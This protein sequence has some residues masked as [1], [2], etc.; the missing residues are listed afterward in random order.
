MMDIHFLE[1][2]IHSYYLCSSIHSLKYMNLC[3]RFKQADT[4]KTNKNLGGIGTSLSLLGLIF[5]VDCTTKT[6]ALILVVIYGVS[7][8]A[9]IT[10]AFTAAFTIAP[11]FT[12]I[13]HS[14][15]GFAGGIAFLL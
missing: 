9:N 12:G 8:S 14:L 5:L 4:H 3:V 7:F 15:A 10:G 6:L 1:R 13:I 11:P 2:C